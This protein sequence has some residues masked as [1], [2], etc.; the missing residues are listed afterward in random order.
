LDLDVTGSKLWM[1]NF[2]REQLRK[3]EKL[4]LGRFTE[5]DVRVTDKLVAITVKRLTHLTTLYDSNTTI[6][7]LKHRKRRAERKLFSGQTNTH[8]NGTTVASRMQDNG[9]TRHARKK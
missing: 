3:F 6:T 9:N 1:I 8:N 7:G 4:G 5:H 2:Y